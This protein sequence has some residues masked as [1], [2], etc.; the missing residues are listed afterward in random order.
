M[1]FSTVN[2]VEIYYEYEKSDNPKGTIA[3]LNGVMA[4]VS[5]WE[6]YRDF[7]INL[8]YNV[9]LHDF[10]GQLKSEK[11]ES[12][13]T[14]DDHCD[15]LLALMNF[16][17]IGC[18]NL[19]GTSYGGEAALYFAVKYPE[20]VSSMTV[21]DSVSELSPLLNAA[22]S[23]WIPAAETADGS[24]FYKLVLPWLYSSSFIENN[25]TVLSERQRGMERLTEDYFRGQISLYKSFLKI[26]ITSELNK[27][28]CPALIICGEEDILKPPAFSRII[29]DKISGSQYITIPGCGHVAIFEKPNELKSLISGFLA[30]L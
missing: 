21:I 22:V 27:I 29:A 23:S 28:N 26:N 9:L 24:S 20:K 4:S 13:F 18:T 11:P 3:L 16:L 12:A 8:G 30:G 2:G 1:L 5:G 17:G 14:F 7:F 15:D 10:R 6:L 19:I 25:E